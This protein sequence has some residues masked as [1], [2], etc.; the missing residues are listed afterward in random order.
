MIS[1]SKTNFV[2]SGTSNGLLLAA[3]DGVTNKQFF[4]KITNNKLSLTMRAAILLSALATVLAVADVGTNPA[5]VC[6]FCILG[7]GLVEESA[8][9]IHMIP[10]LQSKCTT[11]SCKTAVEQFVLR[12]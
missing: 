2:V 3:R 4:C 10:Y 9:Q 8:F 5:Y 11:D 1:H 7:L 6:S 12:I